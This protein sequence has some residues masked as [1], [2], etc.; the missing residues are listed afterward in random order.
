MAPTKGPGRQQQSLELNLF[1]DLVRTFR[2]FDLATV[3]E[4]V[5]KSLQANMGLD[6]GSLL[7]LSEQ[8]QY[9]ERVFRIGFGPERHISD[10]FGLSK[11]DIEGLVRDMIP[12]LKIYGPAEPGTPVP[13]VEGHPIGALAIFPFQLVYDYAGLLL[14]AVNASREGDTM[15][16]PQGFRLL[17]PIIGHHAFAL[18][19]AL[20]VKR[21]NELITKDDLTL[22]FNRRFFEDYVQEEVERARRYNNPLALIFMDLDGLREVNSRF[23]HPMG[24]RTLQEAAARLMNAVRNIDKVFRYGGDEFC[25]LLPET[26]AK[27]ASEVAERIRQRLATT[28]FLMEET[29]GVEITA[30]FGVAAYPNHALSKEELVRKADEAMYTVKSGQKNS[31]QVATPL[32]RF[33]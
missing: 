33:P 2:S 22:A 19:N 25:I 4:E 10:R 14:L 18:K 5:L 29:G 9:V 12:K 27:G 24:S 1:R 17:E 7:I 3:A 28:P 11:S 32:K 13:L 26:D 31:I 30:S 23:G 15:L 8:G 20:T 21:L 6:Y 16:N